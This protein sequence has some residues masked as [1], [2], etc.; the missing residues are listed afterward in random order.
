MH[1]SRLTGNFPI[2]K[3]LLEVGPFAFICVPVFRRGGDERV[4][5]PA[6]TLA[7]RPLFSSSALRFLKA[8]ARLTGSD[9]Y[10][11]LINSVVDDSEK[12][13]VNIF[14]FTLAEYTVP[15]WCS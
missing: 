1:H 11:C 7:A 6:P 14:P 5:K 15:C 12:Y 13:Q 8:L 3:V 10:S 2:P 4:D 9:D